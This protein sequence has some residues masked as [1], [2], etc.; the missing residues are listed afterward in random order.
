MPIYPP[1][2]EPT[3]KV[4]IL[5]RRIHELERFVTGNFSKEKVV[6]AAEKVRMAQLN[7]LKARLALI[8]PF[9]RADDTK[10]VERL[11]EKIQRDMIEWAEIKVDKI[12]ELYQEDKHH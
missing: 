7:L 9:K 5:E 8:K 1:R 12:I 6:N 2:N 11:R 10:E 4:E 3:R